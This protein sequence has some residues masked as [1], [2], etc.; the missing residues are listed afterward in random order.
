MRRINL[1]AGSDIRAG[2]TNVDRVKLPGIDTVHDLDVAPW[3]WETASVDEINAMDVFEHVDDALLFVNE[4]GRILKPGG[5]LRIRT[6]YWKHENSYTDPS[7]KRH[8]T[9]KSLDYWCPG[10]E[11]GD[12]YGSAY[13]SEGV[14]FI[15]VKAELEGSELLF[16]LRRL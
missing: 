11:F 6:G 8:S 10:T 14:G 5:I 3:P 12:K 15:K 1:G 2:W 7:H 16:V 13:A 9:E 4:C